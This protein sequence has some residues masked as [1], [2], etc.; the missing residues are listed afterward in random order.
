[1]GQ[2]QI[3]DR[4]DDVLDNAGIIRVGPSFTSAPFSH[5]PAPS[6][7]TG[8]NTNTIYVLC[9]RSASC[10]VFT[11][12]PAAFFGLDIS[13]SERK[14]INALASTHIPSEKDTRSVQVQSCLVV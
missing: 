14:A 11:L 4:V 10:H 13:P 12:N 2:K 5:P 9:M 6:P 8:S 7:R 1:M 3:N